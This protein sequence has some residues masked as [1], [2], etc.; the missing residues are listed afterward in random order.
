MFKEFAKV[1]I[2]VIASLFVILLLAVLLFPKFSINRILDD[3]K[4]YTLNIVS[5]KNEKIVSK[6]FNAISLSL[7]D[8]K[9]KEAFYEIVNNSNI[10][11]DTFLSAQ[12]DYYDRLIAFLIVI[13][14]LYTICAYF[15]VKSVSEEKAKQ[16]CAEYIEKEMKKPEVKEIIAI[17]VAEQM[18]S[19]YISDKIDEKI[20]DILSKKTEEESQPI[21]SSQAPIDKPTKMEDKKETKEPK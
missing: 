6:D 2:F 18:K 7:L 11:L 5:E 8:K 14:G 15:Y 13:I 3:K 4:H 19:S 1:F 16:M 17:N 10:T 9:N 21:T 20:D 12:L